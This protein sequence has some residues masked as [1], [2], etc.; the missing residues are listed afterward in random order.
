[1]PMTVQQ[2]VDLR[3]D[4]GDVS[5]AFQDPELHRLWDRT[6]G[7]ADEYTHLKA[8]KALMFEGLLNNAA[9]LHDYTAGATSEKLSQ[10][11]ANLK[12]RLKA[13]E[14]ALEAAMGQKTGLSVAG[15]RAYP[16]PTRV[17]PDENGNVPDQWWKSRNP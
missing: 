9:K 12:D 14:P 6:S 2:I 15:L 3:A 11:V 10:I 7:A 4:M 17:E 5:E 16:H 8:V 1:M 13:Y